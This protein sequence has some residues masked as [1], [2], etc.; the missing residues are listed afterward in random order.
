MI[1]GIPAVFLKHKVTFRTDPSAGYGRSER[2]RELGSLMIALE[3]LPSDF[4]HIRE[5]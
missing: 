2:E 1:T 5:K 4:F 3:C